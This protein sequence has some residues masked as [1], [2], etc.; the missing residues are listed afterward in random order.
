MDPVSL[1]KQLRDN[2]ADLNDFYKEL[3]SWGEDMKR[4]NEFN[5]TPTEKKSS[6]ESRRSNLTK[7]KNATEVKSKLK[8]KVGFTDYS[9]WEKFD[10]DAECEKVDYNEN[11]ES[12][13]TDECDETARDEAYLQKE[14]G[15]VFVKEKKWDEAIN[16]YSRA[17]AVYSYDPV[18]Y[19]NR[20]LCY[21]KKEDYVKAEL[22][23]TMSI[24][25]DGTY[26]K[27]F[28]RRAAAKEALGQLTEA[29]SDLLRVLELEPKNKE[30]KSNLD[31]LK[32]KLQKESVAV[33]TQ[34]P[35]SKFT[36]SRSKKLYSDNKNKYVSTSANSVKAPV[37][38]I[39]VNAVTKPAHLQSKKP[40]QRVEIQ[41]T[42]GIED[43][44]V[45]DQGQ[46]FPKPCDAVKTLN[47]DD[48]KVVERQSQD[49][50]VNEIIKENKNHTNNIK[51][52]K[53][54]MELVAPVNCV[55]FC[56]QWRHLKTLE[57]KYFYLKLIKAE[58]LPTIFKESL[59]SMVFSEILEVLVK[60]F[61]KNGDDVYNFL[62]FLSE[63]KRFSTLTM[64]MDERDKNC[65][66]IA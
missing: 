13:L 48:L 61:V 7:K 2:A 21:L 17:I 4:K 24:K 42:M 11:D 36:A 6:S 16:C 39:L 38:I 8:S 56:S 65:E 51:M 59:E 40:L 5:E 63:M 23:C 22:D 18:F 31:A 26:V 20:A 62:K 27:A 28:Q 45:K 53:S 44:T 34:R 3:K 14:K 33:T 54:E 30:S 25:L 41:E 49:P 35:V 19:A 10:A 9:A 50:S 1:Q 52:A 66:Y 29:E 58:N 57:K 55:Q 47:T 37:D 32:Q 64:F 43:N 60:S 12:D 15:N 46:V